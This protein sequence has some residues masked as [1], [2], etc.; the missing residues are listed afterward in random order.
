MSAAH[1]LT[2]FDHPSSRD[3]LAI[4][5]RTE[6]H[7]NALQL[8]VPRHKCALLVPSERTAELYVTYAPRTRPYRPKACMSVRRTIRVVRPHCTK[9]REHSEDIGTVSASG[10]LHILGPRYTPCFGIRCDEKGVGEK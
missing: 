4:P 2:R 3:T 8:Q 9:L 5:H 1:G 10:S 7:P 6:P